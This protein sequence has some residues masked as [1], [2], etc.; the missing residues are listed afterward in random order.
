MSAQEFAAGF[1]WFALF[2][3][4]LIADRRRDRRKGR[5]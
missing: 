1:A 2:I 3:I 4:I 5:R